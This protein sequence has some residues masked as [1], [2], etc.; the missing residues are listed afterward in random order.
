ME[1]KKAEPKKSSNLPQS[2]QSKTSRL[3]YYSNPPR[4]NPS[5][6]SYN[7]VPNV[8]CN[9]SSGR[10]DPYRGN[11]GFYDR[12]HMYDRMGGFGRY[13]AGLEG[14]GG[15]P[16]FG[17][18][19]RF[20]LYGGGDGTYSGEGLSGHMGGGATENFGGYVVSSPYD[21]A[22]GDFGSRSTPDRSGGSFTGGSGRYQPYA[23]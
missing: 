23:R 15:R 16:S 12:P 11:G 21:S 1:I 8:F 17:Y 3:A 2:A 14:Y 9:Y 5:A 10:F 19:S 18:P 20:G 22:L 7:G 13:Y 4:H 6:D